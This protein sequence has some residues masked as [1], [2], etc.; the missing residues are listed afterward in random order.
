MGI[1]SPG[2]PTIG[3]VTTVGMGGSGCS[4][5]ESCQ[6]RRAPYHTDEDSG[7]LSASVPGRRGSYASANHEGMDGCLKGCLMVG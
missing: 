5:K 3:S 7:S 1:E 6:D 2:R 4:L